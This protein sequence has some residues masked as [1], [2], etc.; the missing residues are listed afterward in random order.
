MNEQTMI[1]LKKCYNRIVNFLVM[2]VVGLVKS[3]ILGYVIYYV[4]T[5][6]I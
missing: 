2:T 5:L 6:P 1:A 4:A 3:Q